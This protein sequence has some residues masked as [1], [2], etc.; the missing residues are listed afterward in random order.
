LLPVPV[1]PSTSCLLGLLQDVL[2]DPLNTLMVVNSRLQN[3]LKG[4]GAARRARAGPV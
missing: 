4:S 2:D 1:L 3:A